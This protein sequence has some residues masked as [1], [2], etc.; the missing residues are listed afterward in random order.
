MLCF[1]EIYAN[2][3]CKKLSLWLYT[4][5]PKEKSFI[6]LMSP[7]L[8]LLLFVIRIRNLFHSIR[9]TVC[10]KLAFKE[11]CNTRWKIL[12]TQHFAWKFKTIP[13]LTKVLLLLFLQTKHCLL[14]DYW[15][16]TESCKWSGKVCEESCGA[17][18]AWFS[19]C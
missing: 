4:V 7:I 19:P 6:L 3:N 18:W 12:I 11:A 14:S 8:Q 5:H 17:L 2:G 1:S 10:Y 13:A 9:Y 15:D 16:A